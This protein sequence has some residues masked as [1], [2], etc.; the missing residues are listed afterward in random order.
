MLVM[1]VDERYGALP[2][3]DDVI[4]EI[5]QA[6]E[7]EDYPRAVRLLREK[8]YIGT[9]SK[10]FDSEDI[11][12]DQFK[13]PFQMNE[14]IAFIAELDDDVWEILRLTFHRQLAKE[15]VQKD[16]Y[17]QLGGV[18]EARNRWD[19][20]RALWHRVDMPRDLA[21]DELECW[22]DMTEEQWK[23]LSRTVRWQ[24]M[25]LVPIYFFLFL[26]SVAFFSLILFS[27]PPPSSI[28][29]GFMLFIIFGA[30][31]SILY[32]IWFFIQRGRKLRG[33]VK[34]KAKSS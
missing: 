15:A 19:I 8:R 29:D 30:M 6:I 18:L 9:R 12:R 5:K 33:K 3:A 21:D 14:D 20:L 24:Q 22:E 26:V 11:D 25:S 1:I 28:I 4:A 17:I 23:R 27:S 32:A 13:P 7:A 16:L 34:K 31:I 10:I 2:M